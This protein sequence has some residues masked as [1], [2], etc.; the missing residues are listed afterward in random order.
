MA[1][2]GAAAMAAAAAALGA[3]PVAAGTAA[4][5]ALAALENKKLEL[6]ERLL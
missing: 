6:A 2:A 3:A 4:M 5:H 1:V